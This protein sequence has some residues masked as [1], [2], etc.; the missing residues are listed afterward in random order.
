MFGNAVQADNCAQWTS[1]GPCIWLRGHNPR[2]HRPYFD[3][4]LPGKN[5][6]REHVFFKLLRERWGAV[7]YL[8]GADDNMLCGHF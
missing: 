2:W 3:Q 8:F 6:C 5:G 1:W 7:C 4:L